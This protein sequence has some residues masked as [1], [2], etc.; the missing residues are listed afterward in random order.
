MLYIGRYVAFTLSAPY[1]C[2]AYKDAM[3]DIMPFVDIV[4]G[5]RHEAAAYA[6]ANE[7]S[8]DDITDI[9]RHIARL[10]KANGRRGRI[11]VITCG[12]RPAVVIE[13]G[14]ERR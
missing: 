10:P 3:A 12:S 8:V 11:V 4:F 6:A 9:A 1:A 7:L 5:N 2:R 14:V 13:N